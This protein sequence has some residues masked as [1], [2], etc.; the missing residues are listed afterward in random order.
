[1]ISKI[2]SAIG[3][4]NNPVAL[5]WSDTAPEDA[6]QFKS[7][8]W[9]CV[10]SLFATVA[11]RGKTG[12]FCRE[13][14]GCWGGGVGLGFGN[15]YEAFPGGVAGFCGFLA[16]GNDKTEAGRQIG[17]GLAQAG[18]KQLADDFLLGE[19][20]LKS[21]ETT[22]HFLKALPLCDIPA[23]YVVVKPLSLVDA[24]NDVVKNVTFFV[25]PDPLSALTVLANHTHPEFE[26]IGMPY[27]AAC[28]V[29]GILAYRELTQPHPRALV[30]MTDI[31]ARKNTRA[32]LG[33]TAM[34]M[35]IPW[36]MFLSMEDEVENSFFQ[37]E[38]WHTLQGEHAKA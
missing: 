22:E 13:T 16:D 3:L 9:G 7:G 5:I 30:G 18:A 38:T 4:T 11:T 35:T 10:V 36:P 37:R 27:A 12:V 31:S 17:N 24:A 6:L 23:K 25:E 28:Q 2:A 19:R 21:P 20:Y 8:R 34:S 32:S 15:C 26:N 33:R 14:Y 29:I 1:M